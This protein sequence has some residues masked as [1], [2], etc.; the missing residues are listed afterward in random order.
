MEENDYN[1]PTYTIDHGNAGYE[2]V[3]RERLKLMTRLKKEQGKLC[4][5]R[6]LVLKTL[7]KLDPPRQDYNYTIAAT[8][9]SLMKD[10]PFRKDLPGVE[11]IQF[12]DYTLKYGGDC[13]DLSLCYSV[14]CFTAGV[15]TKW[16]IS[17]QFG[18]QFDHVAVFVPGIGV[19]DLTAPW[20]KFP[21]P[22]NLFQGHEII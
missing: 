19:S 12:P 3:M 17:K 13:D 6:T 11:T 10:I 21:L 7:D 2:T 14:L 5:Y 15:D 1:R 16:I 9:F 20:K 4:K 8:V 18:T 22:L